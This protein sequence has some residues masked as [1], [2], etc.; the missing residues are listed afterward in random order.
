LFLE[1]LQ[2]S[3]YTVSGSLGFQTLFSSASLE[4][5]TNYWQTAD[6]ILFVIIRNKNSKSLRELVLWV[7]FLYKSE[8]KLPL[9]L[10]RGA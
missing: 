1:Q 7:I 4:R 10:F 3:G 8:L 5:S 2:L 9:S 6:N